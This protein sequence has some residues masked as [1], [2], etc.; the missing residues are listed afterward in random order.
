MSEPTHE[1]PSRPPGEPSVS[2][3]TLTAGEELLAIAALQKSM[4]LRQGGD[5]SDWFFLA[6]AHWQSGSKEEARR[7]YDKAADWMTKSASHDEELARFRAEAAE[8]LGVD[9]K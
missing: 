6:M 3:A 2:S 9:A 7:W 4:E 8:L 1:T 5:G